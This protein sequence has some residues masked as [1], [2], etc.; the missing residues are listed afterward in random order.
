VTQICGGENLIVRETVLIP[1][2]LVAMEVFAR[3]AEAE[4]F[5]EAARRLQI[6]KSVVSKHG[7]R[8]EKRLGVRLLNRTT[9]SVAL[10]EPGQRMATHLVVAS[11]D[12][13][14][15][16]SRAEFNAYHAQCQGR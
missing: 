15:S 10:T 6:S 2:D 8:L 12:H 5:S 7:T 14:G 13:D 11:L 4:S 3:V 9:R 16:V 1:V